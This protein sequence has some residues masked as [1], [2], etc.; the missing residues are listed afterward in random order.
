MPNDLPP[1]HTGYQQSQ[2]RT[3]HRVRGRWAEPRSGRRA[4]GI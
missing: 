1:W 3:A 4:G 2:R